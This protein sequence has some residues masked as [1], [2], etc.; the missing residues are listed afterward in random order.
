[1]RLQSISELVLLFTLPRN[2]RF[3][4]LLCCVFSDANLRV[5]CFFRCLIFKVLGTLISDVPALS[6]CPVPQVL[7]YITTPSSVCQHL[8]PTFLP[9]LSTS[10]TLIRAFS[11]VERYYIYINNE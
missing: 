5:P 10:F 3:P 4:E 2:F 9:F 7:D 8:F 11:D 6:R 1:M